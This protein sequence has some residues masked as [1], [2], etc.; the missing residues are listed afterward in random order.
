MMQNSGASRRR[1]ACSCLKLER[2]LCED[3]ATQ[4]VIASAAKQSIPPRKEKNGLLRRGACRRARIRATR[5]LLA[6]T[7]SRRAPHPLSPSPGLPPSLKL[8]RA[9]QIACPVE[10]LA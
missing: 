3:K 10:A 7:V 2:P 4:T 9:R 6:M 5:W 8:R 1:N